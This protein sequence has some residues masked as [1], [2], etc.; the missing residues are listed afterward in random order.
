MT[1]MSFDADGK[2]RGNTGDGGFPVTGTYR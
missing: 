2:P 1:K